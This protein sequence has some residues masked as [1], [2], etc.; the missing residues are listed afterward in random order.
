M[1]DS[2]PEYVLGTDAVELER[3]GLQHRLWADAAHSLWRRAAFGPG[4]RL[5]D[6]GCGPGYAS[7]DLAQLVGPTGAVVG[8]D[9]SERF[10]AEANRR[11]DALGLDHADARAGDVQRLEEAFPGE[12]AASFDGAYARW[13]LCFVSDPAA[14]VAGVA[15]LLRPGARFVVQDY[16]NY[17]TMTLAPREPRF[18]ELVDAIH[19]SLTDRG[20][21]P[22]VMGR[23]PAM[24]DD[25]GFD[26][27][28]LDVQQRIARPGDA[29]MGWPDTFWASV[30]PRL[31]SGG[32]LTQT[33]ADDF[34]GL[35]SVV[36][37]DPR[38]FVVPP[39]VYELVAVRR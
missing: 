11:F 9:E 6:V 28:H 20:G 36:R 10:V 8:V 31:V 13:V 30:V 39:P 25:A 29:M 23:M 1:S 22:D 17:R 37:D 15:A 12:H 18:D 24:L 33:Q 32:Y 26:L 21:D 19:R 35:W 4:D 14:V 5:L 27:A 38:R 16:F 7:V 2:A 34:R 3:L